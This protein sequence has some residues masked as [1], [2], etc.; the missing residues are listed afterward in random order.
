MK[1][2]SVY[3]TLI[4]FQV[5]SAF[6]ES[7]GVSIPYK[8]VERRLGDIDE[9]WADVQKANDKLNWKAE[10]SLRDM[11][12]HSWKWQSKYPMGY[13]PIDPP[14]DC[15]AKKNGVSNGNHSTNSINGSNGQSL[16]GTKA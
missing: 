12:A 2:C 14:I 7:T 4:D 10:L 16:N 1:W 6:E 15:I 11:C 13:Q 8:I 3:E 9:L 5:I